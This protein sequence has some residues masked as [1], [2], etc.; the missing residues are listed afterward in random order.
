MVTKRKVFSAI[1]FVFC[2]LAGEAYL[3]FG[4]LI[5]TASAQQ[6]TQ[7]LSLAFPN[8]TA[9]NT[10]TITGQSLQGLLTGTPTAAANY[11]TDTATN[12]CA[13]IGSVLGTP[14]PPGTSWDWYIKNTSGGANTITVVAGSGV[15]LSGTGTVVQNNVRQFRWQVVNCTAG[16]QA[17]NLFSLNTSAF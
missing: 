5:P 7:A 15:T 11:T 14:A 1:L 12:V 6:Q 4:A 9:T 16:A 17:L 3:H 8:T 13:A 10:A 2:V